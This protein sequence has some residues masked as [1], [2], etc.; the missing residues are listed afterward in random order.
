MNTSTE[1]VNQLTAALEQTRSAAEVIQNLI[2][3][4]DYQDEGA[5]VTHAAARLLEAAAHL[6]QSEDEPA[7]EAIESAEDLL[8]ALWEMIEGEIDGDD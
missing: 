6:M 7:L 3:D 8:E 4:H 2:A 5:L 1:A